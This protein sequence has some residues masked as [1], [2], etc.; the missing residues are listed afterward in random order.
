[1]CRLNQVLLPEPGKPI[2]STT[3]PFDFRAS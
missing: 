1:L 3:A 2:D